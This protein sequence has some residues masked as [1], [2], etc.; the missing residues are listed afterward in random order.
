MESS[1]NLKGSFKHDITSYPENFTAM[2]NAA[3]A[4]A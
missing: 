4:I 2:G 1:V 3:Q